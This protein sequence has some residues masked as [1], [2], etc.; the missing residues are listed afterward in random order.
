MAEEEEHHLLRGVWLPSQ[1]EKPPTITHAG[2][3]LEKRK[4]LYDKIRK[5]C[6]ED[7]QN[8][9]CPNPNPTHEPAAKWQ[10]S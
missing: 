1:V 10:R 6:Q 4:Y 8:L 9:V 7:V 3:S 5:Y 2:L